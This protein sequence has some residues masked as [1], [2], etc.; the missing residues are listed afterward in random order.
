MATIIVVE[1]DLDIND[2]ETIALKN[3]GYDVIS[4]TCAGEFWE[5]MKHRTPEL[6]LLD[7]MLEDEDGLAILKKLRENE[8]TAG[9]P[10]IFVT[11][12]TTELDKVRGLDSGADDY[13]TKPFGIMELIS[14]VK[15]VLRR[16][17]RGVP[18]NII[19]IG[20]LKV[21]LV[22]RRVYVDM[23]EVALTFK[24][25][26]LLKY[27]TTHRGAAIPRSELMDKIW[28]I[29]FEGES[30]TLDVHIMTLRKKLGDAGDYI[31]TVKNV[32]YRIEETQS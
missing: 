11:A 24:E 20:K 6:V 21:D 17:E 15:A 5:V 32:G 8:K 3:I 10:V 7:I 28:G 23:K 2:I 18:S 9:L 4:C 16:S 1:D 12:K 22:Q 14:R 19:E 29:D 13:L 26:E 25:F 31:R 27:L 30:R